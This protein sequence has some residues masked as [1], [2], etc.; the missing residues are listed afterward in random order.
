[1]KKA[2]FTVIY[3][4]LSI[5]I[6]YHTSAASAV[7][8]I[9]STNHGWEVHKNSSHQTPEIPAGAR[10]A[11]EKYN[12]IYAGNPLD[13]SVY[14][15]IDLG[16]ETG[17]TEDVLDVLKKHGVKATFF[18]TSHYLEKN[19]AIVDRIVREGHSLQNHTAGYKHLDQLG[20]SLVKNEIMDLHEKVKDRYGISMKYLRL[21]YEEWSER[22]LSIADKCGYRTVFWSVACVDWVEGSDANYTY[23]SVFN[24]IHNGAVVMV[25]TVSKSSPSAIDMIITGLKGQGYG[26][27]KLDF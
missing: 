1:M 19:G 4:L 2:L 10:A 16:Y 26:F 14:L 11:I 5:L 20:D 8:N 12:G 15:T 13:R 6:I 7:R 27:K 23:S 21:P 9:D 18:I 22:V 24:N 17:N 25:H 3:I